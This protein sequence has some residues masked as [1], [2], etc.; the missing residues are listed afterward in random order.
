MFYIEPFNEPASPPELISLDQLQLCE[1]N[2]DKTKDKAVL[3][4]L[5]SVRKIFPSLKRDKNAQNTENKNLK[6]INSELVDGV[7]GNRMP[8]KNV[9]KD[10]SL[11]VTPPKKASGKR[12]DLEGILG[13]IPGKEKRRKNSQ[14][15]A[16]DFK[17]C[18]KGFVPDGPALQSGELKI[19]ESNYHFFFLYKN[20]II[21]L[22]G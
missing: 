11:I 2:K 10:V 14:S 12:N 16:T 7:D 5:G 17:I 21:F 3:Q 8:G 9:K 4:K 13:I 6:N 20:Y 1:V 22:F 19:G 15:G 18:I